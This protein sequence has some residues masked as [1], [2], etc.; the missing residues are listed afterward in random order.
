LVKSV[1]RNVVGY[2]ILHGENVLFEQL[3]ELVG[4]GGHV[5]LRREGRGPDQQLVDQDSQTPDVQALVVL[6][7]FDHLR[8]QVIWRPTK[9]LS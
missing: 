9:C 4:G 3:L 5:A 6:L 8:R 7:A 2:F 1:Y